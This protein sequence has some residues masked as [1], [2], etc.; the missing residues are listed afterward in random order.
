MLVYYYYQLAPHALARFN[1]L[2]SFLLRFSNVLSPITNN[3]ILYKRNLMLLRLFNATSFVWI[4]KFRQTRPIPHLYIRHSINHTTSAS[5]YTSRQ[6]FENEWSYYISNGHFS[7]FL[8][9]FAPC[10]VILGQLWTYSM[11]KGER[12]CHRFL[13]HAPPFSGSATTSFF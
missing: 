8:P 11:Y 4:V 5:W 1:I 13:I 9:R 6:T 2:P 3:L 10:D 7:Y 12:H